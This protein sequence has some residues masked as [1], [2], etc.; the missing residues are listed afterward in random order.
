M[1]IDDRIDIA[2]AAHD[3]ANNLAE[4]NTIRLNGILA[5]LAAIEGV[6]QELLDNF[7]EIGA[8]HIHL[9]ERLHTREPRRTAT[10]RR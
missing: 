4:K 5:R 8:C 1:L 10:C 9:I 7:V 6:R 3:T 2:L